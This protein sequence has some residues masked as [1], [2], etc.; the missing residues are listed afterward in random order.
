[1]AAWKEKL[2]AAKDKITSK[3]TLKSEKK[4]SR[5]QK[6]GNQKKVRVIVLIVVLVLIVLAVAGF[7]L[8]RKS[9]TKTAGDSE[10]NT[11][12]A[13]RGTIT[14]EISSS[15]TIAAINQ[16]NITSLVSGKIVEAD[17]EE[18]DMV[19]EGQI[20]YRIDSSTAD[21]QLKSAEGSAER[22][23]T[24]YEDAINDYSEAE[25]LYGDYTYKSTRTGY[26]KKLYI[27]TG[28]K[29]SGNTQLA[30]IY[31]EQQMKIRVPFLAGDAAAIGAGNTVIL[32][33]SD[34]L[35]QL[36][37]TV[38][39]VSNMDEVLEGGR[40]VRY[41]TIEVQNPGGLTTEMVAT[42]MIGS[43]F[44][45]GEGNFEATVDTRLNAE[46]NG[47]VEIEEVLVHEGDFVTEGTPI[48]RMTEASG[49]KLLKTYS[50]ALDQ[51]KEKLE[52]A[53][54]QLTDAEESAGNYTITAPVAGRIISKS[55]KAG[56]KINAGSGG[57]NSTLCIL[58]DISAYTFEMSVDELD[59]QSVEV[60]QQVRVEAD[61]FAGQ[62][63]YGKV[64]NVSLVSSAQ[65]GVSTYPVT[66]T[67]DET[68]DLLPGMNVDGYII[69]GSSEDCV[70]VPADALMRGNQVYVKDDSVKESVGVVPA[71]FRAVEVEA[72]LSNEDYVEIKN[73]ISEGDIVYLPDTSESQMFMMPGD[74]GGGGFGGGL[75]SGGGT[76]GGFPGGGSSGG[77]SGGSGGPGGGFGGGRP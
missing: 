55:Y 34:T 36:S 57:N 12:M 5:T 54:N 4:T 19:A 20:L 59:V 44:S 70:M 9:G 11:G 50:D 52:N 32:I 76:S 65:N 71:G 74:F 30:D 53:E 17:F 27:E 26:I 72:G 1:M 33:L 24:S 75:P 47:N 6:S 69:L 31:N 42:A 64:T 58:Y 56:D 22:S 37:G 77:R 29:V 61:A 2:E 67:L 62:T 14:S 51:A 10:V 66:V 21:S 16:Y 63:F 28:D 7:F 48:F 46:L 15:G 13:V 35:E 8:F 49:K 43:L 45:A 18:G 41:V 25:E 40:I 3:L 38:T 60:G 68:Y 39:S 73:G 23:R